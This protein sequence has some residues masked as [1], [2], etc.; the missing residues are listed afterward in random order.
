MLCLKFYD[1]KDVKDIDMYE[2]RRKMMVKD[3][4]FEFRKARRQICL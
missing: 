2:Y 3:Y 4:T 1:K